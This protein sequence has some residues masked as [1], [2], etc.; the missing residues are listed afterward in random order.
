M[1]VIFTNSD[2]WIEHHEVPVTLA[3]GE[4]NNDSAAITLDK[5]GRF[6]GATVIGDSVTVL[7][8]GAQMGQVAFRTAGGATFTY[9]DVI[10]AFILRVAKAA[11]AGGATIIYHVLVFVK[12]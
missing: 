9:G 11:T 4:S 7:E 1:T 8:S 5:S 10:N 2:F 6:A 12:K 3:A